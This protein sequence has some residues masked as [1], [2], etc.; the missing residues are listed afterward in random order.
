[1][2]TMPVTCDGLAQLWEHARRIGTT[3]AWA[4]LALEWAAKANEKLVELRDAKNQAYIDGLKE[5]LTRFAWSKEGVQY[6]GTSGT[7]LQEALAQVDDLQKTLAQI[8]EQ[9]L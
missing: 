1:M 2:T 5:G 7:T 3:D 4:V 9:A 6:V 8:N